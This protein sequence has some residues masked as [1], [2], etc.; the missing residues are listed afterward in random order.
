MNLSVSGHKP[1]AGQPLPRFSVQTPAGD[2]L[3]LGGD[4]GTWQLLVIYRG[5]HC[6]W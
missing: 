2:A 5:L 1:R 4:T 6:G 3:E